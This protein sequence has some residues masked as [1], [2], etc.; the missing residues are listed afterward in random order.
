MRSLLAVIMVLSA[1]SETEDPS[2]ATGCFR[3]A[4]EVFAAKQEAALRATTVE[5]D[6][7]ACQGSVD[8]GLAIC[9]VHVDAYVDEDG[10]AHKVTSATIGG[11]NEDG[12]YSQSTIRCHFFCAGTACLM[13][14]CVA[15]ATGCTA[16]NCGDDCVGL[17]YPESI[18]IP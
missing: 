12:V 13:D 16:Y 1:C 2:P 17:C 8:D 3:E 4:P 5:P 9:D 11:A 10:A 7:P 18:P 6:R 14:G 15:T